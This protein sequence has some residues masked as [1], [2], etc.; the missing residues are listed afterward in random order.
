MAVERKRAAVKKSPAGTDAARGRKKALDAGTLNAMIA[1]KAYELY[2]QRGYQD[3]NDLNNW[4]EAE[5]IVKG[6]VSSR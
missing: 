4:V 1:Q 3:G 5:R 2:A 6:S